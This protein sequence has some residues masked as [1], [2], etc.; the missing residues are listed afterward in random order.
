[1]P[2]NACRG[3][4]STDKIQVRI[5]GED[6]PN[7]QPYKTLPLRVHEHQTMLDMYHKS[8]ISKLISEWKISILTAVQT[9]CFIPLQLY[10][11]GWCCVN[12]VA[13]LWLLLFVVVRPCGHQFAPSEESET[14]GC[15]HCPSSVALNG[16]LCGK[17]PICPLV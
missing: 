1:M 11:S 3:R 14:P 15:S 17:D 6:D 12:A 16:D 2:R 10:Y 7:L 8:V 9:A 13:V 4:E 5:N